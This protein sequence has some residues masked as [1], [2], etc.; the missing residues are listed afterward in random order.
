MKDNSLL[1]KNVG[2]WIRVSTEDQARGDS[3]EV[4]EARAR[5]YATQRGWTVRELYDLGGTSGKAVSKPPEA[6]QMMA[7]VKG[8]H[9]TGL[10]FSKLARLSRNAR[11]LQDFGD[12]FRT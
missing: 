5:A 6:K 3:P 11:E 10:I 4:H 2:I 1:P 7:D 8:G 12:Y 9:I